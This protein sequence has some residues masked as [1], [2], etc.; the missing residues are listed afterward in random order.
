MKII[1]IRMH[2]DGKPK[3]IR[4]GKPGCDH[5]APCHTIIYK[6]RW[7]ITGVYGMRTVS[8]IEVSACICKRIFGTSAATETFMNMKTENTLAA[9]SGPRGDPFDGNGDQRSLA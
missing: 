2:D 1:G 8:R 6:K 9:G 7:Q 5:S 3:N 4:H